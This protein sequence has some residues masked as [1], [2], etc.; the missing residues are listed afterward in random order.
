MFTD[1]QR[2]NCVCSVIRPARSHYC[3]R[4]PIPFLTDPSISDS[5]H[6][7]QLEPIIKLHLEFKYKIQLLN[8]LERYPPFR[9]RE[10]K[11]PFQYKTPILVQVY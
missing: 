10:F 6:T 8:T 3:R 5:K 7:T 4:Y 11:S 9:E 1:M 2:D